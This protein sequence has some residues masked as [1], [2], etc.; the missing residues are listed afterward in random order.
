MNCPW[1]WPAKAEKQTAHLYEGRTA[2]RRTALVIEN[3]GTAESEKAVALGLKWLASHQQPRGGWS[4]DHTKCRSCRGRC[5]SPGVHPS[6]TGS[7]GLVLLPFLGAGQTHQ[8]GE[9]QETV[10][11]AIYYL[12]SKM[13]IGQS[14]HWGFARRTRRKC[15][16]KESLR[17]PFVNYTR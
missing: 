17:W 1:L 6:T 4:F 5:S 12:I 8:T 7:T 13:K 16:A 3:G 15:I 11:K 2:A 14:H 9:Y 10:R